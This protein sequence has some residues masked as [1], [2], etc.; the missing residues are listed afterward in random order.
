MKCFIDLH[1]RYRSLLL[2]LLLSGAAPFL[3]KAQSND[4]SIKG[5]VRNEKGEPIAGVS[6]VAKLSARNLSIGATTDS[7]GVFQFNRLPPGGLYSFTFSTVGYEEQTLSGY[8]L[9]GG[10]A[11]TLTIKLRE[12]VGTLNDVV[13]VGYGTLRKKE[14]SG[15]I[16]SLRASDI[17]DQSVT[18]IDQALAGKLAGVQVLQNNGAPG[19]S[20]SIRIRGITSISAG[21][22]PLYVIDGFPISNDLLG[23]LQPTDNLTPGSTSYQKAPDGMSTLNPDDI[24]SIEVLKDA[25][26][27]SIYGSRAS[28]GVILITTKKGKKS[29]TPTISL[30]SYGGSQELA[31]KIKMMNAYQW[32]QLDYDAKNNSYTDA[33]PGAQISD[34]NTVRANPIYQIPPQILPY[35]AGQKGLTNTDWQDAIYRD[36][37]IQSHTLSVSGGSDKVQYYVSGNFFDQDGI[38]VGSDY[39]RYSLRANLTANLTSRLRIG[40]NV[41]PT[42]ESYDLVNTDGPWSANGVINI[43][44]K[45]APIFPVYNP[46]GS[47]AVSTT[48]GKHVYENG[49]G[50][51][52]TAGDNPVA[53]ALLVKD[54]LN[55]TRSINSLYG[56]YEFI[57]GL[58]LKSF[59]ATD[60]NYFTRNFFHPSTVGYASPIQLVPSLATASSQTGST[61]NWL[62]E[63]TLNYAVDIHDVHHIKVLLGYTAQK[64]RADNNEINGTNFPNDQV[65]TLNAAGQITGGNSYAAQWSLL[66]YLGRVN[67]NFHDRYF[68]T[69]SLRRDGSSRF[70]AD[71]KWGYFP[72]VSGAWLISGEPFFHAPAVSELKLRASYGF[73]GNFNIGNYASYALLSPTSN[74]VLG[75]GTG[76]VVNGVGLS[77]PPNP[78]LGW[79]K[80]GMTNLGV[81]LGLLQN[82]IYVTADYYKTITSHLLLNVNVPFTTGFSTA[83]ENIGKVQNQGVELGITSHNLVGAFKWTTNLNISVNRNKVLALGPNGDPIISNGGVTGEFITEIGKPI[84]NYY[85]YVNGGVFKDQTDVNNSAHYP[86]AK[87]GDRKFVDINHDGVISASDETILGNYLP[88]YIWGMNNDFRYRNFDLSVALQAVEGNQVMNLQR[89][90]IY[91]SEGNMNQMIQDWG[92]WRSPSNPG[93]GNS[94]RPNRISNANSEQISSFHVEDGSFVRLRNVS[95][96]YT[97]NTARLLKSK[98]KSCRFYI[99]GQNLYTWTHYLGYNPEVNARPTNNLSQGEDYGTYPVA[100]TIIGGINLSL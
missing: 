54:K 75:A 81:D 16:A 79:E 33:I 77:Q 25:S 39:K 3:A 18:N 44:L 22:D 4:A 35:L 24:E 74:Y 47:L 20:M 60:V 48:D 94:M 69:A 92:Y 59:V 66:S 5:V 55:H 61:T 83:L 27:A 42:F 45:T 68:L 70:G 19:G 53:L 71:N 80:T 76:S 88:K 90:Y 82:R 7:Q 10:V 31:H 63:N 99:S 30:S 6:V 56:E 73:T 32:S 97:V 43:A 85:G 36:A 62:W 49:I 17:K 98:I 67:Y 21:S 37:A 57:K 84:G 2:L 91:N 93:D 34:N 46:D 51:D 12:Q 41:N 15:A 38:V 64:E 50:Y 11:V 28:N 87:P 65:Q 8:T 26:S 14:V 86:T 78:D 29:E 1:K 23:L 95:L 40:L 96:G 52:I 89:R 100:R 58:S 13:V 9:K 72:S